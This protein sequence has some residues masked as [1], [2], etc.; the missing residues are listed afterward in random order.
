MTN[1]EKWKSELELVDMAWHFMQG[2]CALCPL[3]EDEKNEC[4]VQRFRSNLWYERTLRICKH[5]LEGWANEE[6]KE[7]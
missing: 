5:N 2:G 6:V 3:A 1:F 7:E 4:A